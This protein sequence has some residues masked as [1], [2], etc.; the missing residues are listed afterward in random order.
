MNIVFFCQSCGARFEVAE[1]SAGKRGRCKQCGQMMSIPRAA[2]IA[3]MVGMPALATADVGAGPRGEAGGASS[4]IASASSSVALAPLT[5]DRLPIGSKARPGKPTWDDD[6]GD[7]KPYKL[8]APMPRTAGSSGKPVSGIKMLWRR[9]L[10]HV[11]KLFRWLNQT[12]Y[13]VSVPFLMLIVLG[14]I[15]RSRPLALLGATVVILLSVGRIVAGVANIVVIPFRD[16][17]TRGILFLI[18]PFTF[19]YLA[20]H[21][22]TLKKPT[23]RV[24]GPVVTIVLVVL[25]L[26]FLPALRQGG[27]PGGDMKTQLRTGVESLGQ[28]MRSEVEKAEGLDLR[29]LEAQAEGTLRSAVKKANLSIPGDGTPPTAAD[30]EVKTKP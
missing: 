5:V 7:S 28:E 27:K 24:V 18:P 26:T 8:A 22:R 12:A 3:S 10:G 20:E 6:L 25:A 17:I 19:F 13:L 15:M 23:M 9:G 1:A 30:N 21:W 4:W 14:V 16:G 2:E 29:K 11:Q